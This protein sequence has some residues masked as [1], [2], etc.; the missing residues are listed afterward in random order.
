MRRALLASLLALA[1]A[2]PAADAGAQADIDGPDCAHDVQDF[3]DAPE[4]VDFDFYIARFPTCLRPSPAGS[5]E[6]SCAPRGTPPGTT[7]YVKH[8]QGAGTGYWLR[9]FCGTALSGVDTDLDGKFS[10]GIA[11]PNTCD[12]AVPVDPPPPVTV[13]YGQDEY[14]GDD[15]D[16][17][18]VNDLLLMCESNVLFFQT[19][20]CG[21]PR[22]AYLNVLVDM[23]MDGDWNDNGDCVNA[24]CVHEW[25]IKNY[26]V[27]IAS[28]CESHATPPFPGG[29]QEGRA[30][31][32]LSIT[33]EPVDDDFPWAG[34]AHRPDGSY[35]GGETEDFVVSITTGLP[36]TRASWGGLKIRYR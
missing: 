18:G 27:T 29:T 35:A 8:V 31:A 23:S 9:I 11:S 13:L 3:G 16:A 6:A 17:G 4:D 36:A 15:G 14:Q 28:G 5:L 12:P 2:L 32:R 21:G 7:G 1:G 19:A 26:P 10:L 20:N 34:S 24:G 30:W 22:I 25:A 33:D